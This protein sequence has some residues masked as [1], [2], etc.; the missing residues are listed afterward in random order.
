MLNIVL[1]GEGQIL[2]CAVHVGVGSAAGPT[3]VMAKR[4]H[5]AL[6][7]PVPPKEMPV[8]VPFGCV[9]VQPPTA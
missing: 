3:G 1:E 6:P 4:L 9:A 2:P 5:E 8:A 7:R